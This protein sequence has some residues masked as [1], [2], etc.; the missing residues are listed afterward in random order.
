MGPFDKGCF[1]SNLYFME[2]SFCPLLIE[3]LL[4]NFTHGMT[5]KLS[6]QTQVVI[7]CTN[8]QSVV[9]FSLMK[10]YFIVVCKMSS[11]LSECVKDNRLSNRLSVTQ[12]CPSEISGCKFIL[13]CKWEDAFKIRPLKCSLGFT[14]NVFSNFYWHYLSCER[15]VWFT[16]LI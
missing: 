15:T 6:C 5:A 12:W 2:I 11:T 10:M 4:Q 13:L 8:I 3:W 7:F 14:W 16:C 9:K 1:H